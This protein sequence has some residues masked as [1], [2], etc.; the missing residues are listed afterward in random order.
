MRLQRLQATLLYSFLVKSGF[1]QVSGSM[2]TIG[3]GSFK[4]YVSLVKS[5]EQ[6]L[7]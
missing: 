6:K 3:T 7:L 5:S 2:N 4:C 1:G